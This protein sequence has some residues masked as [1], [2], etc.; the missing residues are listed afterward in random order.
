MILLDT[1]VLIY[2]STPRSP[3]RK[4]A[5]QTIA[6]AVSGDG[7]AVNA[8]SVAE[9]CAGDAEPGTVADRVRSWGVT[10]ID[11]PAAAA[12]P[13]ARAYVKYRERRRAEAGK[14][15]SPLP[16]PDFFIGAH[17]E[18]MGWALATAD[19]G[20]FRTYFPLVALVTP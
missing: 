1:N 20:R 17:A 4:W 11:V 12:E 5:R 16:L 10:V 6:D 3:L 8:V 9:I 19:A 13:C 15:V 7:A 2:A 14:D 18:I